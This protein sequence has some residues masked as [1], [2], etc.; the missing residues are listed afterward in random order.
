MGV[1]RETVDRAAAEY[2]LPARAAEQIAR[3]LDALASEPDPHTTVSEPARALD[4]HVRDSLVALRADRVAS[5]RSIV[6]IGAGAGFPGLPLAIALPDARV[7]LVES[8]SRKC[9]VIERLAGAA[10]IGNARPVHARVEDWARTEGAQSYE[11]ATARAVAPLAVLVEYAAPLL[12]LGGTF[13]AWKGAVSPDE[14]AS[15]AAAATEIG[16]DPL[17]PMTVAPYSG[18]RDLHLHLYSKVRDTPGRF[19][20]KPGIAAKR[21][22]GANKREAPP[23]T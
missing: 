21:P 15:G 7:D 19:P 5:V 23:L 4:V 11:L 10:G 22:L 6:D 9:A 12:V 16:L 8:A 18:A 3:L 13:V 2:T 14:R 17:E 1:S 20:R